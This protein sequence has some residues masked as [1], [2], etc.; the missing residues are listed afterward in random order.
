MKH[1]ATS[2]YRHSTFSTFTIGTAK[3][4]KKY[5]LHNRAGGREN[6]VVIGAKFV[7]VRI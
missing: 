1:V 2:E 3:F 7:L 4:L 6:G 5:V